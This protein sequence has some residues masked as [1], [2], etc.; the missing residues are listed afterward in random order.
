MMIIW[1]GYGLIV[2]VLFAL[3]LFFLMEFSKYFQ[4]V[5]TMTL[6]ELSLA[7]SGALLWIIGRHFMLE[8]PL[9]KVFVAKGFQK[10]KRRRGDSFYF[11]H[12]KHWGAIM[13]SLSLTMAI[14]NIISGW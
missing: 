13:L 3:I 7:I 9:V 14:M 2:P 4:S 12:I 8:D 11:I 6:V 1:R 5:S 10:I